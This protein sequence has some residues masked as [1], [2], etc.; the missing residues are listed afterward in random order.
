MT[1][2]AS[3]TFSSGRTTRF[4]YA[5]NHA[6]ARFRDNLVQVW[7]ATGAVQ[8]S[9]VYDADDMVV[10][11]TVGSSSWTIAYTPSSTQLL[12]EVEDRSGNVTEW[13]FNVAGMPTRER[14]YTRGLRTGE[15][16][17]FETQYEVGTNGLIEAVVMPR[18]NRSEYTYSG[19]LDLLEVRH[20]TTNTTS[21]NTTDLVHPGS[22]GR[23]RRCPRRRTPAGTSPRSRW[24]RSAG[25]PPSTGRR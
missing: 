12:A 3:A 1:T 13:R 14:T 24:I 25:P 16:T 22:T 7:S 21:D 17:Y 8:Q 15:P 4:S 18:G 9:L 6:D 10:T 19:E 20:K 5:P 11:E 2:P 23:T